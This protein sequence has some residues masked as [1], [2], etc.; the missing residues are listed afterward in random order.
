[1]YHKIRISL[2]IFIIMVLTTMVLTTTAF[3]ADDGNPQVQPKIL[4]LENYLDIAF[5]N[6]Q[7]VKAAVQN[8]IIS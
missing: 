7:E 8:I 1:M 4:S 6:S 2:L 5:K 3:A